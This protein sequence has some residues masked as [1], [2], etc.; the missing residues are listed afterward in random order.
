MSIFLFVFLFSLCNGLVIEQPKPPKYI[1]SSSTTLSRMI[2]SHS[3]IIDGN[4]IWF[5]PREQDNL[6]AR[7]ITDMSKEDIVLFPDE[8]LLSTYDQL[9]ENAC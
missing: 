1:I 8:Y 6:G 4:E 7:E 3:C 5:K 2:S 9:C